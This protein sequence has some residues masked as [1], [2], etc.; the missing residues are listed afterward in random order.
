MFLTLPTFIEIRLLW[1][2]NSLKQRLQSKCTDTGVRSWWSDTKTIIWRHGAISTDIKLS[3][4]SVV[5]V[6]TGP[7]LKILKL[8]HPEPMMCFKFYSRWFFVPFQ[9]S[10]WQVVFAFFYRKQLIH[11]LHLLLRKKELMIHF[12][13]GRWRFIHQ[14]LMVLVFMLNP[15]LCWVTLESLKSDCVLHNGW[16]TCLSWPS[17]NNNK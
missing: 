9:M 7:K 13:H 12:I 5:H 1:H 6:K 2:I 14:R 3:G 4:K 16:T 10:L 11:I 15:R 17:L 8:K